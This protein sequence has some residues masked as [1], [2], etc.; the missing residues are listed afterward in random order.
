MRLLRRGDFFTIRNSC[1]DTV[2]AVPFVHWASSR[3]GGRNDMSKYLIGCT[4]AAF[5]ALLTQ[6]VLAGDLKAEIS[7]AGQHADMAAG[8]ADL[9]TAHMHLHHTINCIVG[10]NGAGYDKTQMNPCANQGNGALADATSASTK[11]N[12]QNAVNEAQAGLASSDLATAKKDASAAS[13]TLKSTS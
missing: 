5:A 4:A 11:T 6:P 2:A 12:L 1:H 13:A 3:L 9:N 10:P 8:A 7:T